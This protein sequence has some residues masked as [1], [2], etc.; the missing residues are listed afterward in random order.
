MPLQRDKLRQLP[1]IQHSNSLFSLFKTWVIAFVCRSVG[2][3]KKTNFQWMVTSLCYGV[4]SFFE[5]WKLQYILTR[6][7]R[8]TSVTQKTRQKIA[9]HQLLMTLSDVD[10]SPTTLYVV[11]RPEDPSL[12]FGIVRNVSWKMTGISVKLGLILLPAMRFDPTHESL[13]M[14]HVSP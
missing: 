2:M 11:V 5:L 8:F 12:S 7:Y 3:L 10:W 14:I 9:D 1:S 13:T 4:V 6:S